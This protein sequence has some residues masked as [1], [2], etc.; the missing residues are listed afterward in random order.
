MR[1]SSIPIVPAP[2]RTE[3]KIRPGAGEA[4][5]TV[6]MM[7]AAQA[8]LR[9]GALALSDG[10]RAVTFGELDALADGLAARLIERGAGPEIPIGVWLDRTIELA[11]TWLAVF[12]A[13]AAYVPLDPAAP[14]ERIAFM[15]RDSGAPVLVADPRSRAVPSGPWAAIA[16][17]AAPRGGAAIE[18][19]EA[20]PAER[21]AYVIYTSG[22]T[23]EPKG[24]QIEHHGLANLVAWHRR[25]FALTPDDRT[26]QIANPAFDAATW[27]IW[28][29][30]AAGASVHFPDGEARGSAPAL[31]DWLVNR[32]ITVSFVPTALAEEL[33]DF[34]WPAETS[35]RVLLTGGDT[36]HRRPSP[37]LP[38]RLVNNYGPTEGTVVAT[39]GEV[40][41]G[42]GDGSLPSIGWPIDNVETIVLREDGSR[43]RN[44]ET[45]ELYLGG[46]GLARG[47]VRRPAETAAR[48]VGHPFRPGDRLYRTG[49]RARRR[50]DGALEFAGRLDDQVKIR[51]HR[52]EPGEIEA[53]LERHPAVVS[54]LAVVREDVPGEKVLAAYVVLARPEDDAALREHLS[55]VLPQYMIP[56]AFVRLEAFPK[57]PHGKFDRAR[58]PA[59]PVA[60]V[61]GEGGSPVERRVAE[62]AVQ[63]LRRERVG[64]DENFFA[65]GGHSLLGTQMIARLRDAFGVEI[66]LRSVFESPTIARLSA[67]IE[68]RVRRRVEEMSEEEAGRLAA[69][70]AG[71]AEVA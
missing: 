3:R 4:A 60:A 17:D 31:R 28:P 24:V 36:L 65:I 9:P 7:V 30:L 16:P 26:S 19:P 48:F 56:S 64:P 37:G 18:P 12:K 34:D 69:G 35:L 57:T 1:T 47:Y 38:F 11:I 43:A 10:R 67:E 55:V 33:L 59:P 71:P 25:A 51:G 22:S 44:G 61:S 32:K 8:R 49:D 13:G 23:G 45:G 39:S 66:P 27:E 41:A 70:A 58:L 63:L 53:A 29:S 5:P 68:R 6:P 14:A 21:L 50:G 62:I 40:P 46:A 52:I 42:E 20:V 54:S 2:L 15:L